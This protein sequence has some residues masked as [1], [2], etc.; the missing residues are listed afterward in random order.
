MPLTLTPTS[1]CKLGV[2]DLNVK[3]DALLVPGPHLQPLA[4]GIMGQ[5][6]LHMVMFGG[7]YELV[8]FLEAL[9]L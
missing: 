6:P 4:G 1:V 8:P 7:S 3:L 9:H 5:T 2:G